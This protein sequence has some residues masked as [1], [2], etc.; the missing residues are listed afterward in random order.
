MLVYALGAYITPIAPS[1]LQKLLFRDGYLLC[2]HD[3]SDC[4]LANYIGRQYVFL[5]VHQEKNPEGDRHLI[6]ASPALQKC[7]E[8]EQATG[9]KFD[10]ICLLAR[11]FTHSSMQYTDFTQWVAA[12]LR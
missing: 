7:V 1:T 12:C 5:F 11:A 2:K 3:I 8:F 6:Q 4:Q 9:I 10:H